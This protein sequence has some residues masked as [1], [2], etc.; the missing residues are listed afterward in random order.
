MLWW[1]EESMV[2]W[3][4]PQGAWAKR[5]CSGQWRRFQRMAELILEL[6]RELGEIE[7]LILRAGCSTLSAPISE[8]MRPTVGQSMPRIKPKISPA[9]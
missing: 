5:S 3:Q 7:A 2:S 9:R 8:A 4:G 1:T 6:G